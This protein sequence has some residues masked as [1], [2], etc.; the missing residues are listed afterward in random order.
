MQSENKYLTCILR[1]N[2]KDDR[3]L[4]KKPHKLKDNEATSL[5][6]CKKNSQPRILYLTKKSFK[7]KVKIKTKYMQRLK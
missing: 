6:N 1:N 7:G 2:G 5:K 4:V 3:Y